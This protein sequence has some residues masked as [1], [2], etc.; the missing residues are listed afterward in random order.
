MTFAFVTR[1]VNNNLLKKIAIRIKELR[2]LRR[3]TQADFFED[4]GINIGRIERGINDLTISNMHRIC[5]YFEIS[6]EDFFKEI[7]D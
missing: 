3:I 6:L 4:T 1:Y 2:E 5:E 7:K